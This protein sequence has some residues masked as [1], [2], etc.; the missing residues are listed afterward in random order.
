MKKKPLADKI[1]RVVVEC[2]INVKAGSVQHAKEVAELDT[3]YAIEYAR[4]TNPN[5]HF[6]DTIPYKRHGFLAKKVVLIDPA[7]LVVNE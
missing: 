7:D 5:A 2:H 1:Y 4:Y 6:V 3:R